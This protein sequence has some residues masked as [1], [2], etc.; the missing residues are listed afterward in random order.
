MSAPSSSPAPLRNGIALRDLAAQLGAELVGDGAIVVRRVGS[1]EH[2]AGDAVAFLGQARLRGAAA[3]TAAAAVIVTAADVDATPRARLVHPDP[4][5]AFAR[6]ASLLHPAPPVVP[7]IDA[8]ARVD[9]TA[10]V[11]STAHVGAFAVIGARARVGPRSDVGAHAFLGDDASIGADVR[12]G[13]RVTI[14]HACH[15][16]D[17]TLVHAGAVIGADGFGMAETD[18]R[19]LKVPQVGRVV[20]GADCEIGANTTIDRGAIDDTV[21]EDDV[22]LDNQIQI[23]HNCRI[24]AHTAIA[25]CTGIAGSVVIGR[26]VRIGGATMIAGHLSIADHTVLAG[27]SGVSGSIRNAGVYASAAP[28]LPMRDWRHVVVEIRRLPRLAAR[29]AALEGREAATGPEP[30]DDSC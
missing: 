2:A 7:G 16:G 27:G 12:L 24:G 4:H 29:V 6:C 18:G 10:V 30:G 1:L 17:R 26:N 5:V 22:K 3:T 8:T 14:Y 13:P 21:L 20:I 9:P 25:G 15:L 23:G 11:D 19:W 28:I